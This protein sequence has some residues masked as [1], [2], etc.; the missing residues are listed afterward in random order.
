MSGPPRAP[1]IGDEAM[2]SDAT[3]LL[4]RG[5]IMDI[6][7]APTEAGTWTPDG[8][9]GYYRFEPKFAPGTRIAYIAVLGNPMMHEVD[10]AG[11]KAQR[12]GVW[13]AA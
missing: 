9:G 11:Y 8:V 3:G 4:W 2:F 6:R 1:Q 5:R 7:P 12:D 10:V 13:R